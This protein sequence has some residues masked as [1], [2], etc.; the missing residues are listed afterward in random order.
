MA[1]SSGL[2]EQASCRAAG[3]RRCAEECAYALIRAH[4]G[5]Y[6]RSIPANEVA[7]ACDLEDG[8][9]VDLDYDGIPDECPL[10]GDIDG[11]GPVNVKSQCMHC[12]Q[13]ACAAACLTK[14]MVKTSEGPVVWRSDKCMG[15]RFCMISCPFDIPK[16]EYHSA[17]PRIQKCRMCWDRLAEG[18]VPAC[19]ENC[20]A[21]CTV[22]GKRSELLDLAR[23]RI[24]AE[25]DKYVHH[26]YGEH[27]AGGT[28]VACTRGVEDETI[29]P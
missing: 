24:Y 23:A 17:N 1:R 3:W 2:G 7:D 5:L 25:P 14:A 22:F 20:P 18:E 16:F 13:P 4:S 19:V 28:S 27:E 15:C 6:K 10:I 26:I 29:V 11:N 21:K 9:L 12:L 8:T